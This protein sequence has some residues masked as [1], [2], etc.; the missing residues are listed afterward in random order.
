MASS[1]MYLWILAIRV[2]EKEPLCSQAGVANE[3]ANQWMARTRV[4]HDYVQKTRGQITKLAKQPLDSV[5]Q[6]NE[7]V[8]KETRSLRSMAGTQQDGPQ[9]V[10]C[11]WLLDHHFPREVG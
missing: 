9:G 10:C 11:S 3:V 7:D 2:S 4:L 6:P 8:L 5:P 1:G